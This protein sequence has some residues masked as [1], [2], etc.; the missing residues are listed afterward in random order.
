MRLLTYSLVYII[1]TGLICESWE[2][3]FL[4]FDIISSTGSTKI[5]LGNSE[6]IALKI[7]HFVS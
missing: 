7:S 3:Q 6:Y 4:N 5:V 1:L 2:K